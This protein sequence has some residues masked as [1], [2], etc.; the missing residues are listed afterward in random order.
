[1][2]ENLKNHLKIHEDEIKC[3]ICGVGVKMINMKRHMESNHTE[4]KFECKH[5]GKILKTRC[6]LRNHV[7]YHV[8]VFDCNFC[9]EKF[10]VKSHLKDHLKWHEDPESFACKICGK[11]FKET[12]NL[13]IHYKNHEEV[14]FL[15]FNC[16]R[17]NYSTE[18]QDR[19]V[20]HEEKHDRQESLKEAKKKWIKCEFCP[21]LLKNKLKLASHIWKV[22]KE[23]M[24]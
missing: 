22:H 18:S 12:R 17:C 24:E 11:M 10:S 2:R 9:E 16:S 23:K 8:Q 13:R 21:V 1:M 7:R 4:G 6:E 15:K 20:V 5:C 19:L 14:N 3:E